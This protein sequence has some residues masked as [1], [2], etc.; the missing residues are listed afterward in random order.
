MKIT[1]LGQFGLLIE[2][3]ESSVMVDPYLTDR[4]YE[5]VSPDF[6]RLVPPDPRYLSVHPDVI[7]LTHQHGDHLDLP[8]LT[9]VMNGGKRAEVLTGANAW[10]KLREEIGG[11]HN[12]VQMRPGTEWTT[13]DLHIRAVPAVH[14]DD[15]ALGFV[16]HAEGK[17]L[18]LSGDTLYDEAIVRAV[19]EPVDVMY[20]VMNGMGNNM[21]STDA[22]RMAE[23]L[24]PGVAI[25]V[26]WGL[27]E[28][29]S[30]PPQAFIDACASRG[31]RAYL[32]RIYEELTF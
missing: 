30:A 17:T 18:Y 22:A 7:L 6:K 19:K 13:R 21:N 14:S 10:K 23:K 26:H 8:S 12:Y 24:S 4:L 20:V 15:T 5:S 11:D 29:F 16:I 28:K 9:A 2:T 27:F 3:K 31:V 32:A 25:P 1:W